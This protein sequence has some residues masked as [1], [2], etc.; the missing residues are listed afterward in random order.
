MQ[1]RRSTGPRRNRGKSRCK[2]KSKRKAVNSG[3]DA[4]L[5]H[6]RSKKIG[7]RVQILVTR[8][9]HAAHAHV[10]GLSRPGRRDESCSRQGQ[11]VRRRVVI[12]KLRRRHGRHELTAQ[13]HHQSRRQRTKPRVICLLSLLPLFLT[14]PLLSLFF[15]L[16]LYL[17]Q[18][19]C[20]RVLQPIKRIVQYAN[21]VC[22]SARTNAST[23]TSTRART[24]TGT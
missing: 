11:R 10:L 1:P 7:R 18:V 21:D 22:T 20:R 9:H 12:H 4:A 3:H 6:H 13:L 15:L 5:Q 8:S 19:L 24:C 17:A 14:I 23:S 16:L 2:R